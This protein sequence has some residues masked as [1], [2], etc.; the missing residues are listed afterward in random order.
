MAPGRQLAPWSDH[1]S[2]DRRK[3]DGTEELAVAGGAMLAGSSASER[4]EKTSRTWATSK[5][6]PLEDAGEGSPFLPQP[7]S[8]TVKAFS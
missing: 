3:G 8:L 5:E 6:P 1:E 7:P 4:A 2:C